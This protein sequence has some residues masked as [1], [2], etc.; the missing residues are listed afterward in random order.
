[1]ARVNVEE[2]AIAIAAI[3]ASNLGVCKDTV[4]GCLV[5]LWNITQ[6]AQLTNANSTTINSFFRSVQEKRGVNCT[7]FDILIELENHQ[8]I[9]PLDNGEYEIIGNN[10][11]IQ[12]Y[13]E[14]K[15]YAKNG[16]KAKAKRKKLA[17]ASV[18]YNTIQYS[19]IQSNT[20]QNKAIQKEEKK[21]TS[22]LA[23]REREFFALSS[24]IEI[25]NLA[26]EGKLREVW[27]NRVD[28]E[29]VEGEEAKMV[30]WLLANPQKKVTRRGFS[31]FY[32]SWLERGYEQHRKSLKSNTAFRG[33]EQIIADEKKAGQNYD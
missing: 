20:E 9:K 33:I 10:K 32:N 19:S 18:Q 17:V 6:N 3:M 2:S 24:E 28:L 1:M 30:T 4:L 31:R 14:L 12:R 26:N 8:I 21:N 27:I 15:A 13:L 11:H 29:Y 7:P 16:G 5:M 22:A 23:S 25:Q